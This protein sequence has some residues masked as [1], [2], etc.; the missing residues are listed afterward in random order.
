MDGTYDYIQADRI[1]IVS[2]KEGSQLLFWKNTVLPLSSMFV[3]S[4]H[5]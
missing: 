5:L 4:I 3:S 1:L 2:N